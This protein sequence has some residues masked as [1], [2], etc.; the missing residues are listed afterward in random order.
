MTVIL[1][2]MDEERRKLGTKT[3][4]WNNVIELVNTYYDIQKTRIAIGNR[5]KWTDNP[6]IDRV[7]TALNPTTG[8]EGQIKKEIIQQ[9]KLHPLWP[10]IEKCKGMGPVLFAE[11]LHAITGQVHTA[12]C[13]KKREEYYKKK[14]KEEKKKKRPERY[15]CDCLWFEIER[16]KYPS[17]LHRYAGLAPDQKRQKG[18]KSDWN[19]NL[20]RVARGLIA[21]S[22][23]RHNPAY[24]K[25]YREFIEEDKKKNPNLTPAHLRNRGLRKIAKLFLSHLH[26]RWYE[27]RGLK[28]PEPYPQ[29]KGHRIIPPPW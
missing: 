5:L 17:S 3:R 25:I 29:T 6:V 4:P 21:P 12:E 7:H 16:F 2:E 18:V 26:Q 23:V 24:R 28:P 15:T 27:A 8:L 10:R 9:V 1:E 13:L 19:P 20:K 14:Q 11:L 22:L